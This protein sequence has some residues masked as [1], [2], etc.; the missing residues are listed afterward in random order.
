K[1]KDAI[2]A[3]VHAAMARNPL[4]DQLTTKT[5]RALEK[6]EV[7]RRIRAELEPGPSTIAWYYNP[8][9]LVLGFIVVLGL[10]LRCLG[11]GTRDLWTDEAAK[12]AYARLPLPVFMDIMTGGY[13]ENPPLYFLLLGN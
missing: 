13:E 6:L 2:R 1:R 7:G 5:V 12:I 4:C 9:Y 3:E 11:I 10:A 8:V